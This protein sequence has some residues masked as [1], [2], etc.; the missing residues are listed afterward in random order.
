MVP[1]KGASDLT[2]LE[3][4]DSNVALDAQNKRAGRA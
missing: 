3:R 4:M 1:R 2:K